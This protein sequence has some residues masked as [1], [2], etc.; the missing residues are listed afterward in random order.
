MHHE[1]N[2]GLAKL[3]VS[4][5]LLGRLIASLLDGA[6]SVRTT[7]SVRTLDSFLLRRID[8]Q[9]YPPRHNQIALSFR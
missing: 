1:I 4:A 2:N 6:Q 8:I 7:T 9:H 5:V 3:F